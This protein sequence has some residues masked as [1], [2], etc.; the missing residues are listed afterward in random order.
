MA[1]A[2]A[3]QRAMLPGAGQSDYAEGKLDIFAQMIP[4]REVG[5]D[6]Y[7]IVKLDGGRAMVSIGDVCGKGVPASLFMAITQTIMRLVVHFD[8]DLQTEINSANNLLAADNREEMFTTLF[9][10]LFDVSFGTMT[11]CN[12]GHNSPLVLRKDADT[13]EA[14]RACG[15]PLGILED[16]NYVPRS[17][18]LTAG[19]V[20]VLYTDGVTEAENTQKAMFGTNRLEQAVL[21]VRGEPARRVVEHVI[22]RVTEFAKGAV[23]SDDITCVAVV[24]S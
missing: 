8:Q 4:A 17:I 16:T 1:S 7:D 19:D 23:Q 3:I 22:E 24:C 18:A 14:L 5:G 10:G 2:A 9:C 13:F 12:C 20:L 6:L 15:P 21:E 11:Y